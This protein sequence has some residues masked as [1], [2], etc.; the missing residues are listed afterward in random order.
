MVVSDIIMH[1]DLVNIFSNHR[2]CGYTF[3]L[4][5]IF[6][7]WLYITVHHQ[8]SLCECFLDL[9]KQYEFMYLNNLVD[10]LC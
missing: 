2:G 9:S 10:D 1:F 3:T 5:A 8:N 7:W 6:Y 4:Q